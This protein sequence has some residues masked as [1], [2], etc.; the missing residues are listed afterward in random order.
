MQAIEAK[1][2][3]GHGLDFCHHIWKRR[4][5][6]RREPNDKW[7]G[8]QIRIGGAS[9]IGRTRCLTMVGEIDEENRSV[10]P[11]EPFQHIAQEIPGENT[12]TEWCEPVDDEQYQQ[13]K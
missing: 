13:L 6:F 11:L 4:S 7:N 2:L 10:H 3:A 8:H 9:P 5:I 12:T 1:R